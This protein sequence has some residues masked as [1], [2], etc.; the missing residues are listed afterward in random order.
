MQIHELLNNIKWNPKMENT[1]YII[2]YI[3]RGEKRE[4]KEVNSEIIKSVHRSYFTYINENGEETLIPY[5]RILRIINMENNEVIYRKK[6][7]KI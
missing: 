6:N 3:H 2:R 4:Y 7:I 5:H 1:K